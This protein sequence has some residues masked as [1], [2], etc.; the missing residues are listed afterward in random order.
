MHCRQRLHVNELEYQLVSAART[1]PR[2]SVRSVLINNKKGYSGAAC[3]SR[4]IMKL[5]SGDDGQAAVDD[6]VFSDA[7]EVR[8]ERA[9]RLVMMDG[10]NMESL[11]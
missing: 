8:C 3:H 2:C 7:E 1:R 5:E 9:S 10:T 6:D 4:C 11:P